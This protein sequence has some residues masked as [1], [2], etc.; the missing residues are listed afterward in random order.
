[1]DK[2]AIVYLRRSTDKQE[3]SIPDQRK[4][5]QKYAEDNGYKIIREYVDDG[6]SGAATGKREAF[7]R[8]FSE[9]EKPNKDFNT[10]LV[11]DTSRWSREGELENLVYIKKCVDHNVTTHFVLNNFIADGS[12][13]SSAMLLFKGHSDKDF[14]KVLAEKVIGGAKTNAQLGFWNGGF[15]PLMDIKECSTVL[16]ESLKAF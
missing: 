15:F 3:Q 8:M 6:I 9:I 16:Q 10:V 2:K 12:F 4:A 1:M 11:Y 7:K 5:I 14:L 13:V